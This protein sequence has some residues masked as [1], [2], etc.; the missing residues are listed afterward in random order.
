MTKSYTRNFITML[1]GNTLSQMIPF[2]VVPILTR[3][4]TVEDFAD[5]TN[6]MAIISL[7]GIVATGRLELAIPLPKSKEKA[8]NI[9][10]TGFMITILLTLL[11]F[12]FPLMGEQINEMYNSK[13][14]ASYMWFVPISILSYGLLGLASNWVLRMKKYERISIA[15]VSQSLINNGLAALLGYIG[16]GVY[17]LII[18]WVISQYVN[19]FYL[20]FGHLKDIK[21]KKYN[22]QTFNS[23]IKEYKDFPLVNSV[24]AFMDIFA[25]Q[26]LLF[27]MITTY[28]GNTKFGIFAM[29]VKYV[30]API[31]LV[32]SSVSQ[33][34]YV[35]AS[36]ALNENKS[37]KPIAFKTL[38]TT[39][40][41][42]I[43][44]ILVLVFFGPQLFK[45]YLGDDYEMAGVYARCLTPMFFISFLVSPISGIPILHNKQKQG[46]LFSFI[47]YFLILVAL[48]V[49][50]YFKLSF[51]NSLWIYGLFFSL[52]YIFLLVWFYSLIN[53]KR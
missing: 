19:V 18:G 15:K 33:L 7:I 25:T 46:F 51:E 21:I 50:I 5:F 11:S 39:F 45:F 4:F 38:K 32:T 48:Y 14:M 6:I 43:P 16:F 40:L 10:F 27:W 36:N 49:C 20:L 37:I 34:F 31:V 12:I 52:Y 2:L 28:F 29:M 3:V 9:V 26:F 44:F 53:K 42:A 41:F 23:T 35:E 47:W 30:K 1:S 17:G 13:N 24:H 22:L 8:Q